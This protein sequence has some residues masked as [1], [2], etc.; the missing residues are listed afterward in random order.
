M[1]DLDGRA[2]KQD[3]TLAQDWLA[4]DH[5]WAALGSGWCAP[6]QLAQRHAASPMETRRVSDNWRRCRLISWRARSTTVTTGFQIPSQSFVGQQTRI[7][8]GVARSVPARKASG[9]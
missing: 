5:R 9:M 8:N 2:L 6:A 4:T 3:H 1:E 7:P